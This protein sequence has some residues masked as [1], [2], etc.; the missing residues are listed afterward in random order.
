M[1]FGEE[2]YSAQRTANLSYA[3]DNVRQ[4]FTSYERDNESELDFAEAGYY[5]FN[6]GR[7]TSS[8]PLLSSG[9]VEDPQTW[10]RY[11]Y[12]LNNP[13]NY[14][15]PTGLYECK[16]TADECKGF[17][18]NLADAQAKLADIEKKYG[19]NSDEYTKA[20]KSLDSYGCESKG[21]NCM[22]A[23]GK[24]L[25]DDKGNFVKDT[26]N[27]VRVSFDWTGK[28][29]AHTSTDVTS[30]IVKVQFG[31]GNDSN[32]GLIANEGIDSANM[33]SAIKTGKSVGQYESDRDGL[34]VQA[35]FGELR[36][37]ANNKDSAF[38]N[39]TKGQVNNWEKGWETADHATVR[40][41]RNT[42]IDKV[43]T[44]VYK[45]TPKDKRTLVTFPR[46][47]K[48]KR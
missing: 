33:Q 34:F 14:I 25:K 19:K 31:K 3:T 46:G 22:G 36:A 21:G 1:P 47:Y 2:I 23:D 20:Q 16:G 15:D 9:R 40:S 24:A 28:S 42:S 44:D 38:F 12:V 4:K 37:A 5:N 11:A 35:V 18:N 27:N 17:R 39:L 10:N 43:L 26:A 7:F 32:L 6:H 29:P 13:L 30:G 41:N 45:I 48:P 8:D